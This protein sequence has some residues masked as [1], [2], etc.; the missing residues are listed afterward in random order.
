MLPISRFGRYG[1]LGPDDPDNSQPFISALRLLQEQGGLA[2]VQPERNIRTSSA[3]PSE[4]DVS[5]PPHRL[6]RSL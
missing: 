6:L 1:P 5:T 2:P 3:F 4:S